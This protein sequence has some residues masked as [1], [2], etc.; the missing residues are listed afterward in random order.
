M[1]AKKW[2]AVA[3]LLLAVPAEAQQSA[4]TPPLERMLRVE[5]YFGRSVA[6]RRPVTDRE[7]A[8]FMSGELTARFPGLTVV[9]GR[10]AWRHDGHEAREQSKLVIIVLPDNAASRGEI[11]AAT[12]AY[13]HRFH[14]QSVGIVMQSVCAVF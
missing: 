3:L 10:G 1:P 7:W 5:L 11:A 13:N 2:L 6:G 9:D 12:D 14:Q 4:C 8:Q